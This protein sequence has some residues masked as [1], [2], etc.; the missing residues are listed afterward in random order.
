MAR[1][2]LRSPPLR[3]A[4]LKEVIN[5][6][7]HECVSV[8]CQLPNPS[9]LRTGGT[10]SYKD[11]NWSILLKELGSKAPTLLAVLNFNTA[12]S[13]GAASGC[14]DASQKALIPVEVAASILLFKR[15]KNHCRVQTFVGGVL[16][17]GHAAKKVNNVCCFVRIIILFVLKLQVYTR[18]NKLGVCVPHKTVFRLVKKLRKDHDPPVVQWKEA[19]DGRK[20]SVEHHPEQGE[21][22]EPSIATS[23]EESIISISLKASDD[24]DTTAPLRYILTGDSI[25]K[26]VSPRNYD[27]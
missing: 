24:C 18:L 3:Q 2:L 26:N 15:S 23:D 4:M 17:A 27:T 7:K 11:F 9:I 6:V 22:S 19:V 8:C 1:T 20:S 21:E 16:Y 14:S 13:V 12:S 10:T 5:T 25:D